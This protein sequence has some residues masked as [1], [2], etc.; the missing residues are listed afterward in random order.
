MNNI[1]KKIY[2]RGFTLVELMIV[3]IILGLLA[4]IALPNY[5]RSTERAKCSQAIQ[6]LKTMRSAALSFFSDNQTFAGITVQGLEN[7]VGARFFS[8]DAAANAAANENNDW[9]YSIPTTTSTSLQLQATRRRGPHENTV[10]TLT[11]DIT[12]GKQELWGGSYPR[13]DP[14]GW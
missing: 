6:I 14:G 5:A 13:T 8:G 10:M 12:A 2:R 1:R 9:Y 3:T 7:Q 4:T 11:D